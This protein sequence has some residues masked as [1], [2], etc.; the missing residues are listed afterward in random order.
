V[1][2][3]EMKTLL[4]LVIFLFSAQNGVRADSLSLDDLGFKKPQ[5]ESNLDLPFNVQFAGMETDVTAKGMKIESNHE[6]RLVNGVLALSLKSF[7]IIAPS[8]LGMSIEDRVDVSFN[9]NW[10]KQ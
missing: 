2:A 6:N 3:C 7:G 10:K 8:L 1:Y 9:A 5:T 4:C